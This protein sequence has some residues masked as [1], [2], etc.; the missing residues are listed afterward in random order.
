MIAGLDSSL[1][2]PSAAQ[3]RAAGAAGVPLWRRP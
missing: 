2:A 3:A 1:V